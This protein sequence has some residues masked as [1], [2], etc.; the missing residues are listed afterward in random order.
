MQGAEK[1][2]TYK[3]GFV[4]IALPFMTLSEPAEPPKQ[5]YLGDKTWTL[6]DRFEVDEGRDITLKELMD[7]FKERH[8]LEITMMS[9]GKSLIYSFFGNKKSNEEKM[10][11]PI[12][13]IIEN[14][15][16]PF[17]PKEKYVNLEVC[18]Q[19]LDN[20]DDQEVPY[21]RYKFRGF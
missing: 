3:N 10:K 7:I 14:T 5:T 21:I 15:S 13:K 9:A 8:K 4:N 20:G 17:L 11:T 12:S 1:I 2:A 18:V 6:W 19:D 16:G